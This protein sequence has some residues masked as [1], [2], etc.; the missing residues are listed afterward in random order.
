[1]ALLTR[2]PLLPLDIADDASE[3]KSTRPTENYSNSF[4]YQKICQSFQSENTH[5]DQYELPEDAMTHKDQYELSEDAITHKDQYE[6][7]EDAMTHKHQYELPEGA[8]THKDLYELSE[9]AITHKDQYELSEDAIIVLESS[10]IFDN[11]DNSAEF[12]SDCQRVDVTNSNDATTVSL[13]KDSTTEIV[14]KSNDDFF[15]ESYSFDTEMDEFD[16]LCDEI[17][18]RITGNRTTDQLSCPIC[19][20]R[21]NHG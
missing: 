11:Q 18:A 1:M 15:D 16:K 13:P 9:D 8:M 5:K 14:K 19:G 12:S 3:S 4:S 6:L 17:D 10:P 2:V 20:L 7:P 21:L